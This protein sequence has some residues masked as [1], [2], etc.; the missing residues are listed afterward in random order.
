VVEQATGSQIDKQGQ[1]VTV[2]SKEGEQLSISAKVPDEFMFLPLPPGFTPAG[3]ISISSGKDKGITGIWKGKTPVDQIASFFAKEMV[4]S[5]WKEEGAIDTG[6]ASI[7]IY[8]KDS[9]N[10]ILTIAKDTNSDSKMVSA[11][12]T[13]TA[14]AAPSAEP[15]AGGTAPLEQPK[16]QKPAGSGPV[17]TDVASL[18]AE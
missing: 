16:E 5:G 10:I 9:Q 13:S 14:K 18:P 15:S 11:V 8:S 6:G 4:V 2:K 1:S 3:G 7:K 17:T 12:L